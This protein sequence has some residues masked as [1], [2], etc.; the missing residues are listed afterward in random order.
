MSTHA[1]LE[2]PALPEKEQMTVEAGT[3]EW[4]VRISRTPDTESGSNKDVGSGAS[5]GS[6]APAAKSDAPAAKPVESKF[7]RTFWDTAAWRTLRLC[8]K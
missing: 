3:T 6:D 5:G 1:I 7:F 2:L 8:V 4:G